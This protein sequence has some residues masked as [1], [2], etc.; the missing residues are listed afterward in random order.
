MK[1]NKVVFQIVRRGSLNREANPW[2]R[3][4]ESSGTG[5]TGN[6]RVRSCRDNIARRSFASPAS[7]DGG[8]GC[9]Q[10]GGRG[11]RLE[12]RSNVSE[13]VNASSSKASLSCCQARPKGKRP[14][15]LL[16]DWGHTDN[17]VAG[18]EPGANP[19]VFGTRNMLNLLAFFLIEGRRAARRA[20]KSAGKVNWR[21]Q[22][23]SGNRMDRSFIAPCESRPT[24][25]RLCVARALEEPQQGES[26]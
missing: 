26:K 7:R 10:Q 24:S 8:N 21:K 22:R 6:G 17:P 18:V 16:L 25:S 9:Q 14:S 4:R 15:C 23:P 2:F 3:P 5:A 12:G 19:F 20:D 1:Q 11:V 13:L